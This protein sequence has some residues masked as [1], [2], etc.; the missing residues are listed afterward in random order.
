[1]H[2]GPRRR[3]P[4]DNETYYKRLGVSK[5]A[6]M[7]EIKKGFHKLA[8]KLHPDKPGGDKEKF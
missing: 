8:Q 6:T 5:T 7:G 3:E 1:M 2:G 4:V